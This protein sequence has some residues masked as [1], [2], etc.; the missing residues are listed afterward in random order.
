MQVDAIVLAGAKNDGKLRE[1]S[2]SPYEALILINGKPMLNWVVDALKSS[3]H[4][5]RIV[6]VGYPEFKE[7][8]DDDIV[9]LECG[10]SLVENIEIGIDYLGAKNHVLVVTSDIPMLTVEAVDDFLSRCRDQDQDM[11]YP[12]VSKEVNEAVYPGVTRT[13]VKIKDGTF[14]GGN[15]VLVAPK[16]I[17]ESKVVIQRVVALRKKPFE[18]VKLLGFRILVKFVFRCLTIAE[19]ERRVKHHFGINA[20]AVIISYP[21]IGT[22]VDKPSDWELACKILSRQ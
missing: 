16:L 3:E 2:P 7:Y 6:V 14:T 17:Q 10:E 11:F 12:I 18:I 19:V 13:Y 8:M 9:L 22:D 20:K 15:M 4:V 21:Q 5:G 1:I